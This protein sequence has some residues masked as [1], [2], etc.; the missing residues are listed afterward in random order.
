MV[1]APRASTAV[2]LSTDVDNRIHQVVE[3]A[4]IQQS[5]WKRIDNDL[6]AAPYDVFKRELSRLR[7]VTVGHNI[8]SKLVQLTSSHAVDNSSLGMLTKTAPFGMF[9]FT[10]STRPGFSG[11]VYVCGTRVVG[12]HLGG[13]VQN[14]GYSA[15]YIHNLLFRPE[16]SE[17][18]ALLRLVEA[19]L[20]D[21]VVWD[22][23]APEEWQAEHKGRY[24]RI[25][26]EDY[27]EVSKAY[28]DRKQRLRM[29]QM[30][31]HD[32]EYVPECSGNGEAGPYGPDS[33]D[34]LIVIVQQMHDLLQKTRSSLQKN[35]EVMNGHHLMLSQLQSLS[36]STRNELKEQNLLLRKSTSANAALSARCAQLETLCDTLI[37]PKL[38]PTAP[39]EEP[40][41]SSS[42]DTLTLPQ[43]LV[44]PYVPEAGPSEMPWSGTTSMP[45]PPRP[46]SR[47]SS[48]T[49]ET[50]SR[51]SRRKRPSSTQ[52][53][54]QQ[55]QR[56]REKIA[57][58]AGEMDK[59]GK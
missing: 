24:Y 59:P 37:R 58:T 7:T 26:Y 6:A 15:S 8:G 23:V 18:A 48:F 49:S 45:V 11:A 50:A 3:T 57:K 39:K 36:E 16:S 47:G 2:L 17:R 53:K 34:E 35:S 40:G 10:G 52:R 21:E 14:L 46:F 13:G 5:V 20:G 29:P 51:D 1:L 32:V 38:T 31:Y 41:C 30:G 9:E 56:L 43:E 19:G 4:D 33:V 27:L 28:N 55:I 12:M 22:S 54:S 44:C 25:D 42:A